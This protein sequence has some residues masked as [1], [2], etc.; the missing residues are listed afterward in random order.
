M[1]GAM[2]TELGSIAA[3]TNSLVQQIPPTALVYG[4]GRS[5]W[6]FLGQTCPKFT[7]WDTRLFTK[8]SH[9]PVFQWI[10]KQLRSLSSGYE[11]II[12][13]LQRLLAMIEGGNLNPGVNT[14][15][16]TD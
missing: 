7:L 14:V 12:P 6:A 5:C 15:S 2:R 4:S 1:A 11:D 3:R 10:E 9:L 13:L 8:T 16:V